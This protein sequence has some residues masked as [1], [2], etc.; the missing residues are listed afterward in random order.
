MRPSHLRVRSACTGIFCLAIGTKSL[1]FSIVQRKVRDVSQKE[2]VVDMQR[3]IGGLLLSLSISSLAGCRSTGGD[4]GGL[5]PAPK[6]LKASID[7]GIY[8]A[9]DK[10]FTVQVPH[11][12]GSY[13]YT[14]MQ[15]KEQYLDHG[16]DYVSFG[17]AAF[18]QGIYRVDYVV[19]LTPGSMSPG[20][21]ESVPK[22]I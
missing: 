15:V 12:Q 19:R 17:P 20:F 7:D 11:A 16:E 21:E 1:I 2:K 10:S 5:I 14:Y 9:K 22:L 3:I 8:T 6:L 4:I 18:N 13:E